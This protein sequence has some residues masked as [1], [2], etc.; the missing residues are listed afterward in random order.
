MISHHAIVQTDAV[1]HGVRIDEF[2]IVRAGV[3]LGSR[4]RIH[5]HAI[6]E[7]GVVLE[8][9][10]EV[11]P[12][13][14]IGKTPKSPGTLA[15]TPT[16]ERRVLIG[17][18]SQIGPH[19]VIYY[20]VQLGPR[21]LLGESVSIREG[22][23][24]GARC[25]IGPH[26]ALNYDV[27]IGDDSQVRNSCQLGG[28]TR[29]GRRCFISPLLSTA[30]TRAFG[31]RSFEAEY[32]PV[33]VEDDCR[34]GPCV[35]LL[36]GVLVGRDAVVGAGSIVVSSIAPGRLAFGTPAREQRDVDD[37]RDPP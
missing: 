2:A 14:L 21:V 37:P 29:I 33:T 4:V 25:I 22:A 3:T 34:I 7:T 23:R 32:A 15:R 1:G 18:E 20:D 8:D 17:A 12:G 16:Y 19:S 26:C 5:P 6:I 11:W 30:N 28:G 36:P 24:I 9:D 10:V 13:A 27:V 31:R 35:A